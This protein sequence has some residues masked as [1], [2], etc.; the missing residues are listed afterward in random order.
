MNL[1]PLKGTD[2]PNADVR[3]I[4]RFRF[5]GGGEG[6]RGSSQEHAD[7]HRWMFVP[8]DLSP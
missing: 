1:G 7:N 5:Q 4:C 2:E 3:H 6:V 8:L